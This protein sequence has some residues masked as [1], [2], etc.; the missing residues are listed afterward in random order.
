MVLP[1]RNSH[2]SFFIIATIEAI[3][4]VIGFLIAFY[5]FLIIS[6]HLPNVRLLRLFLKCSNIPDLNQ[7]I[8]RYLGGLEDRNRILEDILAKIEKI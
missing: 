7:E 4:I 5:L 6:R 3:W 2:I 8:Q 1:Y